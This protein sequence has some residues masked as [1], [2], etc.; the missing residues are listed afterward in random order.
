MQMVDF[1]STYGR[2]FKLLVLFKMK[3]TVSFRVEM[4]A[5]SEDTQSQTGQ[6]LVRNELMH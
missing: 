1:S 6:T 2:I 5:I 3:G 4:G